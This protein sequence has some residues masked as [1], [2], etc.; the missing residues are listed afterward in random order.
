VTIGSG[1]VIKPASSFFE[2]SVGQPYLELLRHIEKDEFW[3]AQLAHVH[4]D[5]QG[6]VSFLTQV[7]DQRVEFGKPVRMEEKFRK[8]FI[9]YKE[10]LPVVGW[11]KY[12]RLNIEYKDQIICE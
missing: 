10:V 3:N 1:A 9:F 7:G 11:E 4:I 6:N 2:D 12:S 5:G 8:L